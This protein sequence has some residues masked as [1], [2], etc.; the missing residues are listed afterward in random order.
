MG[1]LKNFESWANSDNNNNSSN[2]KRVLNL[3][4]V[5]IGEISHALAK[6]PLKT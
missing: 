1:I 5:P 2:K 4:H 6:T 3:G